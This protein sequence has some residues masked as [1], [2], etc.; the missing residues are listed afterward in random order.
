MNIIKDVLRQCRRGYNKRYMLGEASS[1]Y[2][3][4]GIVQ[5]ETPTPQADAVGLVYADS[6]QYP[7]ELFL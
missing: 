1:Q 7:T 4:I 5:A 6:S 2:S 3:K